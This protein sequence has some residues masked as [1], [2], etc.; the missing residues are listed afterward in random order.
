MRHHAVIWCLRPDCKFLAAPRARTHHAE[1]SKWVLGAFVGL[2][3]VLTA[4]IF[5]SRLE[6]FDWPWQLY[7]LQTVSL[8]ILNFAVI[9]A[10]TVIWKPTEHAQLLV[11][12]QQLSTDDAAGPASAADDDDD[13]GLE[14]AETAP[15]DLV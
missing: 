3:S 15:K 12:M 2:V 6:L 11:T 1:T 14:L 8:E 4:V 13:E 9:A 7:W 5:A 10:V